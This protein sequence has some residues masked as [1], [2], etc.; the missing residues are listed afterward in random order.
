MKL[1]F[2]IDSQFAICLFDL[3]LAIN[4]IFQVSNSWN[5][6][7]IEGLVVF[8]YDGVPPNVPILSNEGYR[9]LCLG[10]SLLE[11]PIQSAACRDRGLSTLRRQ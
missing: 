3:K 11:A 8:A 1:K 7:I 5:L 2:H 6:K 4:C 10:L 9:M